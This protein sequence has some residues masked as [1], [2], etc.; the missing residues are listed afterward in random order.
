M[1]G[2]KLPPWPDTV[3]CLNRLRKKY[4]IAPCSNGS[5]ALMARLAKFGDL[6]WDAIVG[7]DIARDYKPAAQT[8][9]R[10]AAALG[11]GPAKTLM[12]AAHNSD[13]EAAAACGLKTAFFP[14]PKEH[15]PGQTIDLQA[16][17]A[18]DFQRKFNYRS[19]QPGSWIAIRHQNQ[20]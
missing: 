16:T 2:K 15:G 8:Y 6:R 7:A 3:G 12:V 5:I 19:D 11:C 18:W 4:I 20:G 9:L 13:L 1:P 17:G 14:R 10:S